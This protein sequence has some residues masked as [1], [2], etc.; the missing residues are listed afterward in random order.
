[1]QLTSEA[2]PVGT[3]VSEMKEKEEEMKEMEREE[4]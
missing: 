3:T 1:M 2:T 4:A